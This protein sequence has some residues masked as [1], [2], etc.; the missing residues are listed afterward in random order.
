MFKELEEI[1]KDAKIET[2]SHERWHIN[3]IQASLTVK[4]I[5]AKLNEKN[6]ALLSTLDKDKVSPDR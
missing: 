1:T 6:K 4:Q 5:T 3:T 2:G